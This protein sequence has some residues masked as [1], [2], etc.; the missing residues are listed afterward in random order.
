VVEKPQITL[1][2]P[3]PLPSQ[4]S[5]RLDANTSTTQTQSCTFFNERLL[6]LLGRNVRVVRCLRHSAG[7]GLMKSDLFTLLPNSCPREM[8]NTLARGAPLQWPFY[9]HLHT[10]AHFVHYSNLR[11]MRFRGGFSAGLLFI[12]CNVGES[13]YPDRCS[14]YSIQYSIHINV[15]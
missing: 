2:V 11:N 8:Q 13:S 10:R 7:R 15:Q 1:L 14:K 9:E 3:S 12:G 6:L 5:H 4:K